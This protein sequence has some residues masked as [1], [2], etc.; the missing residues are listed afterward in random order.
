MTHKNDMKKSIF[1]TVLAG[2]FWL[3]A[4]SQ[5]ATFTKNSPTDQPQK[6]EQR[7]KLV[8]RKDGKLIEKDTVITSTGGA[9]KFSGDSI[10]VT[11]DKPGQ[12]GMTTV[13]IRQTGTDGGKAGKSSTYTY[14]VTDSAT[15]KAGAAVT[16]LRNARRM[17]IM[18]PG[19]GQ[20]FKG[21][22]PPPAARWRIAGKKSD[23]FAFDPADPSIVSYKKKAVGKDKEKIVIIRKK[24]E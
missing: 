4:E 10:R 12:K 24:G 18:Q 9:F 11:Q 23:R 8:I 5:T 2:S 15:N 14:T 19:E 7:V 22:T 6:K 20:N 17:I 3:S 1:L 16:N 21:T 13:Y